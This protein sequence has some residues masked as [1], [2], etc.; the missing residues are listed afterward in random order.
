MSFTEFF[1]STTALLVWAVVL[2][3]Q[4]VSE[5]VGISVS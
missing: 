2:P 1:L 4:F 5:M 3:V